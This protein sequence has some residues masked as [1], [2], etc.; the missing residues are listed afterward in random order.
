MARATLRRLIEYARQRPLP[1]HVTITTNGCWP[2]ADREWLLDNIDS[3]SLSC[4]GVAEVQNAQ[5]PRAGGGASFEAVRKTIRALD[6]RRIPY[7]IRLTVTDASLDSL[8]PSV[9]MLCRESECAVFQVEP[10][11]AHGRAAQSGSALAGGMRFAAAVVEAYDVAVAAKRD[12]YYSGA[13]PWVLASRFCGALDRA[14]VVTPDGD[15]TACYEVCGREHPLADAFTIGAAA[16]GV[17]GE[18]RARLEAR[19]A[20]RRELCEGC[21]C[22][23]HCAGDCPAKTLDADGEDDRFGMRCEVNRAVTRQLLLRR[24]AASGGVWRG[25]GEHACVVEEVCE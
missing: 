3:V 11:F 16:G 12:L 9:E 7:G 25:D 20:R 21:F 18:R 6:A 10:A 22:Y 1:C 8:V 23:W 2:D 17:D 5:R 4:D 14:L 24:I 13:R 19:I 15:L